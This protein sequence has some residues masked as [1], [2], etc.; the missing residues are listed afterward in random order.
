M[1]DY[2][3]NQKHLTLSDRVYIEQALLQECSFTNIAKV[4]HKDPSTISKE[5]RNN[6]CFLHGEQSARRCRCC[7]NR[8]HC[9]EKN[10]CGN[11]HCHYA[12]HLCGKVDP[13]EY[14]MYFLPWSCNKTTK[15][16]YV[17]NSCKLINTCILEGY[18]YSASKAQAKYEK[19]LVDSRSG[20]NMTTEELQALNALISP[21]VMK[22][23]PLSHIFA[24]HADEIPVSRRTLYN[25]LDQRIFHA[26]NI[27]L[28]RRVRYK[29]RK[30]S[31]SK[32]ENLFNQTYRNRRTY[33]DFE[34]FLEAHPNVDIVEMDTVKGRISSGKCLL[35]LL[36]RSCSFMLIILLPGCTQECVINAI[37]ELTRTL[38]FIVSVNTF[39]S[40]S[41]TMVLNLRIRMVSKK[42]KM[43]STVLMFFTVTLMFQIRKQ[44]WRRITS[45]SGISFQKET[46]CSAS[47]KKISISWQATSTPLP[48]TV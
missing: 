43:E 1:T 16:P 23:Q 38:G 11:V 47:P 2:I 8:S 28:P 18:R 10:V 26:R 29:K 24:V 42:Q 39:L 3:C 44:D 30:K 48:E 12:C 40:F 19:R 37:D 36:F 6:R 33:I 17:C 14:C 34:R 21:L 15:P 27:D 13:T 45:T 20:I 5:I 35:T 46:A 7:M 4:L 25:Y 31:H 41:R 32:N 22:G 9:K